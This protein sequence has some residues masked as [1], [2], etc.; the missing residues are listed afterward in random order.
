M[1]RQVGTLLMV[2]LLQCGLV[3]VMYWPQSAN[4][5]DLKV[6][7]LLPFDPDDVDEIYVEDEKGN[8]AILLKMEDRW[9]LPD[10]AGIPID[11]EMIAKLLSSLSNRAGDWPIAT[12]AS[13]RQRFKMSMTWATSEP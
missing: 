1:N 6:E 11:S 9:L 10:L 4:M 8:E 3:A 7:S 13:S 2:L 12:T 5:D